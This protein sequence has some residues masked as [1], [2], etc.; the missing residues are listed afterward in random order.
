[1]SGGLFLSYLTVVV[2][3]FLIRV[4]PSTRLR[5]A[6]DRSVA[7]FSSFFVFPCTLNAAR[8][9][10]VVSRIFRTFFHR[11]LSCQWANC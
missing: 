9:P 2:N 4:N 10:L 1:M 5:L 7:K 8:Y 11:S 3:S 6:Q